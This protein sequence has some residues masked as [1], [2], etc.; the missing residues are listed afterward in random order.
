MRFPTRQRQRQALALVETRLAI[1]GMLPKPTNTGS[2]T[3]VPI[4][5]EVPYVVR[6]QC[7]EFR[8][9]MHRGIVSALLKSSTFDCR[10]LYNHAGM[11]L[12][13]TTNGTLT[14]A[15]RKD[16]LSCEATLNL[17][18]NT[19]KDLYYAVER[20]NVDQMSCSFLVGSDVWTVD[21]DGLEARRHLHA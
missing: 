11:V 2:L 9:T 3:G 7:G 8:E 17:D 1:G 4:V 6:D 10:F 21:P 20:R 14:F 15:D 16:G 19:A 18:Q 5:Y 12:A 13:R